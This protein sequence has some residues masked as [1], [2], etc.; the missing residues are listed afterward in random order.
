MTAII[1]SLPLAL[2]FPLFSLAL[3]FWVL[4][5]TYMTNTFAAK[6]SRAGGSPDVVSSPI[7]EIVHEITRTF[8]TDVA[9]AGR[10]NFRLFAK[11][12]TASFESRDSDPG[13]SAQPADRSYRAEAAY[14]RYPLDQSALGRKPSDIFA[15][16]LL[17]AWLL[18]AQKPML[19]DFLDSLGI[20]HD[21]DG[22]VEE[23]PESPP[24]EE[25]QKAIDQL[26]TK[27]Q[28]ENLRRL[29][30]RLSRHGQHGQLAAVRRSPAGGRAASVRW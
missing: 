14:D 22:T 26:S 17:Q 23:L 28:A 1:Y 12:A 10:G 29:P 15:A 2:Q 16:H 4:L 5:L 13:Q 21:E 20:K 8:P 19:C 7:A 9:D 30:P 3:V 24:R 25:L 11:G 27:Y 18:G 6:N